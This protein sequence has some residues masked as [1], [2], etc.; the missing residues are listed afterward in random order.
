MGTRLKEPTVNIII[1]SM[2]FVLSRPLTLSSG[3]AKGVKY[4]DRRG[5]GSSISADAIRLARGS[6]G[7]YSRP[8]G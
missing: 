7:N 8:T 2:S 1:S 6:Y 4:W 3:W 5:R